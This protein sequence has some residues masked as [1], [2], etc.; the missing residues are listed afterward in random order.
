MSPTEIAVQEKLTSKNTL[1]TEITADKLAK[2]VKVVVNNTYN[3]A[4]G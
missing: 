3:P 2:G 4:K 1:E